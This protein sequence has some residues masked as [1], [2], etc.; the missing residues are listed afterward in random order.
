[1]ISKL[2]ARKCDSRTGPTAYCFDMFRTK[3][4]LVPLSETHC[5]GLL[6]KSDSKDRKGF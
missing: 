1:M 3:G 4:E 5:L 6:P 2:G